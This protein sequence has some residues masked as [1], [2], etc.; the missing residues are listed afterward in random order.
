MWG[1]LQLAN[2]DLFSPVNSLEKGLINEMNMGNP[3]AKAPALLNTRDFTLEKDL[4]NAMSM[5]ESLGKLQ[6][7]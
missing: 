5:G 1:S 3:L 2:T 7:H 4:L 6:P